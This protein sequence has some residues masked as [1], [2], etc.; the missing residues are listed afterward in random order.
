MNQEIL[1]LQ[2]QKYF[3][4]ELTQEEE[5]ALLKKL[6]RLEGHDSMADEALAVM[7]AARLTPTEAI[8]RR[9]TP[10]KLLAGVAASVAVV[11]GMVSILQ[12]QRSARTFAY[13]SG[14]KTENQQVINDIISTQLN[15]IGESSGLFSQTVASDLDDI[16]EAL[17]A[18]D[19]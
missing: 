12:V 1:H 19:I 2:I 6:L 17:T 16:R 10:M 13:V 4:A 9:R 14:V 15:D 11:I 18:E 8:I 5:K 7:L 3:E